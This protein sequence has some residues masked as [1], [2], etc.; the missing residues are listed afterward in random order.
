MNKLN[1][2]LAGVLAVQLVVLA[3]VLW[4]RRRTESGGKPLIERTAEVTRITIRDA[5]GSEVVLSKTGDQWVLPAADDYPTQADQVSKFLGQMEKIDQGRLVTKTADSHKR[6]KVAANSFERLITLEWADG[7]QHR[8]YLGTSPSYGA[9]HVRLDDQPEVYLTSTLSSADA[10]ATAASWVDTQYLT[11]PQEQ[12]VALNLENGNGRFELIK[13]EAGTW[14]MNGLQVGEMVNENNVTSLLGRVA[15]IRM[16]APL[17]KQARPEYQLDPAAAL[18]EVI[19]RDATGIS[20]TYRLRVGA[21]NEADS[22]YVII[23][24]ESPYYVRVAEYVAQLFVSR[25]RE[26]LIQQPLTPTPAP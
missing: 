11:I 12:I 25:T 6:I 21:K 7:T 9:V 3:V 10:S 15:S 26:E 24:S 2:I 16:I 19:T 18:V 4:P 14:T 5:T 1:R 8:L 13:T 17:G 20:K 23:S 22:T